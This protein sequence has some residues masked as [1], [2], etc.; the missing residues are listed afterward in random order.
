MAYRDAFNPKSR[1][2]K[3]PGKL[4]IGESFLTHWGDIFWNKP[5]LSLIPPSK[6]QDK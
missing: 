1:I 3:T 6:F 4:E 5:H 2:E